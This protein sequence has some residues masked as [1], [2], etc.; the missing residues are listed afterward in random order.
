MEELGELHTINGAEQDYEIGAITDLN[1]KKRGKAL[2]F[3]EIPGFEGA[4]RVVSCT[5]SRA[6]RLASTLGLD[7][8][9]TDM[10]LV[11]ELRGRPAAW[12]RDAPKFPPVRVESGAV[13]E[14]VLHPGEF[15]LTRI[16]APLW[17]EGD[18]GHYIGTGS[19]VITKDPDDDVVNVGTYRVMVHDANSVG[20]FIEPIHGGSIH[21]RKWHERGEPAPVVLSFGHH[22]LVFL[23]SAM[24]LP[25]GLDEFNYVGAIRQAP[26]EVIRGEVT[27][28]PIPADSEIV[29]E[30]WIYPDDLEEEGPFGEFTGYFAGG[31]RP[32]PVVRIER[33]Y[34]RSNPILLGSLP[35]KPPF[36]HS[37]W[38]STIESSM[39]LDRLTAIGLPDITG[40]WKHEAGCAQFFTVVS[41]RQRYAGHAE[42]AGM[43]AATASEGASM[44][45]YVVVVDDDIDVTNL[46]D[47]IWGMS[48]RSDPVKNITFL[49]RTPS[50]P[51]DPLVGETDAEW[52][53]SRAIINA[54][55][56]YGRLAEFA[57]VV[58]VSDG[59]AQSVTEKFGQQ[60]G[61]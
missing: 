31:R 44:G 24:P 27:G 15:D 28:L 42:Q 47:V 53:T 60:L 23:G 20:V 56:P 32:R 57:K 38:R 19:L 6:A 1:A 14:K 46:E 18:G 59:L 17:H 55:R 12:E 58:E 8:R 35:G 4:G 54:C 10:Q 33:V 50:N 43:L 3:D 21:I 49:N 26:V 2:L 7:P 51:L 40:V 16:P 52:L 41:L 22:P 5:M 61:W 9:L 34:Q 29:A 37:Y 48:T 45:R 13:T 39:L 36:D 11:K 25:Y 30:G